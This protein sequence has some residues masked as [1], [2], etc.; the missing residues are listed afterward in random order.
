M[1]LLVKVNAGDVRDLGLIPELEESSGGEDGNPLQY[2]C[3]GN[4]LDEEPG[5]LQSMGSHRITDD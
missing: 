5:G 3:L 4:P 1:V 2:S